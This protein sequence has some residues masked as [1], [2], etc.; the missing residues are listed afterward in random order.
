MPTAAG[1]TAYGSAYAGSASS[2]V[3]RMAKPL[4]SRD[5]FDFTTSGMEMMA[6]DYDPEKISVW[7]NPYYGY[8]PEERDA[9][10]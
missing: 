1:H 3:F 5:T 6:M 2:V 10:D 9:L 7:P 8:N 4:S